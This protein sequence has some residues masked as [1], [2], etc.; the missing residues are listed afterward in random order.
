M[1]RSEV[2]S[3]ECFVLSGK[4]LTGKR[5]K[6]VVGSWVFPYLG[7]KQT[8]LCKFSYSLPGV[9]RPQHKEG[10]PISLIEFRRQ[11]EGNELQRESS[12]DLQKG[13]LNLWL[14]SVFLCLD[15]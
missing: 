5:T 11:L 3:V 6:K 4:R 8:D 13:P 7:G 12:G 14:I 15:M 10:E 2:L 1:A 9:S